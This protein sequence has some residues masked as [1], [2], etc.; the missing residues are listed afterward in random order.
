[1]SR[2]DVVVERL[3]PGV[4]CVRLTGDLENEYAYTLDMQLQRVEAE[5][6]TLV[7]DVRGLSF[8]DAAGMGRLAA[9]GRRAARSGRRLVLVRGERTVAGGLML[10]GLE[11]ACEIVA[12]LPP[13]DVASSLPG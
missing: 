2:L 5:A 1:M 6:S 8:A 7:V 10:A 4:A 12:E 9:A 3:G 11:H 13:D